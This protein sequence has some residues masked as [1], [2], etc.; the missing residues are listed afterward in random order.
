LLEL[1]VDE[2]G[3]SRPTSGEGG[4]FRSVRSAATLLRRAGFTYVRAAADFVEY[5]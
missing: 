4:G 3:I 1:L 2:L 5:Q